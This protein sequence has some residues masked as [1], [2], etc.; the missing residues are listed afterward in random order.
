MGTLMLGGAGERIFD[1]RHVVERTC[2]TNALPSSQHT[3]DDSPLAVN[4]PRPPLSRILAYHVPHLFMNA[5]M[6]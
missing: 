6:P 4:L 3:S 2:S 1:T 5:Q